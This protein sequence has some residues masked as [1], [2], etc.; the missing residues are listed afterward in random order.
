[1]EDGFHQVEKDVS[2]RERAPGLSLASRGMAADASTW[3]RDLCV[4][5]QL[6]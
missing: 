2:R 3:V 5:A 6:C 4:K 1:M